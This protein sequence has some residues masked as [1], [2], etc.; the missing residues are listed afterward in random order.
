MITVFMYNRVMLKKII[1]SFFLVSLVQLS[2]FK[3]IDKASSEQLD[4]AFTRSVTVFA[5]ARSLNGLVSVLQGTE[6]Y[7]TPAGVGMNFAVGQIVDPMNDMIERFSW[8]MLMSSVSLGIQEILLHFGQTSIVQNF[9]ALSV[10]ILLFVLW[11]PKLWHK[12]SFK[13]MFQAFVIISFLRFFV[14]FIV[15]LNESV[16]TYALEEQ[17]EKAKMSLEVT[18][19]QTEIIVHKVRQNQKLHNES[20]LDSFNLSQQVENFKLKM[21]NLWKSLKN[22]FEHAVEYMLSLIAIFLVQSVFLPLG[23]L[24]LSIKIFRVIMHIDITRVIEKN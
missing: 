4:R 16:Y 24:W 10:L 13:L 21:E 3:V 9:L 20:W 17:Y 15:L 18:Q 8:I 6:I 2:F 11:V 19:T 1:I 12:E 22:K 23:F 5:I 7:A 14:P